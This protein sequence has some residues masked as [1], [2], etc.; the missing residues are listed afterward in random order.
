MTPTDLLALVQKQD[1]DNH[2]L[3]LV[4]LNVLKEIGIDKVTGE[5][6]GSGDSPDGCDIEGWVFVN[7][8]HTEQKPGEVV[9]VEEYRAMTAEERAKLQPY[10]E[11]LGEFIFNCSF[12]HWGGWYN[13]EG[14]HG[15]GTFQVRADPP[16]FKIDF[17]HYV[18]TEEYAGDHKYSALNG[19]E[20]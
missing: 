20:V 3:A 16:L 5:Y 17:Y 18:E 7:K 6:R 11:A 4:L 10:E 8:H 13:N 1:A 9:E 15:T 12:D 19:P 2:A 14:G